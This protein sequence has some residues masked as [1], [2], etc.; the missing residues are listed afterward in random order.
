MELYGDEDQADMADR[1]GA[2]HASNPSPLWEVPLLVAAG[3]R[4]DSARRAGSG[5]GSAA[6]VSLARLTMRRTIPGSRSHVA[7]TRTPA[8]GTSTRNSDEAPPR[9]SR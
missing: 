2:V 4:R 5:M 7:V 8:A 3:A 1:D 6:G 9:G